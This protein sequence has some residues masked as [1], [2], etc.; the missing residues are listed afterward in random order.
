[1]NIAEF[2]RVGLTHLQAA[3]GLEHLAIEVKDSDRRAHRFVEEYGTGCWEADVLPA[4]EIAST[5]DAA[6]RS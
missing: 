1:M 5:L 4:A 2:R 3:H 6:I